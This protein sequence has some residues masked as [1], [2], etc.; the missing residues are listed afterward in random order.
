MRTV[1]HP[2]GPVH[3]QPRGMHRRPNSSGLSPL[4]RTATR[5]R[6]SRGDTSSEGTRQHVELE[7]GSKATVVDASAATAIDAS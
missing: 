4:R 3:S 5:P 6:H 7:A 2:V 1:N